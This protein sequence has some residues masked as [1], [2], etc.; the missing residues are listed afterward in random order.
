M[1]PS[2]HTAHGLIKA[3]TPKKQIKGEKMLHRINSDFK[4]R[5]FG[6]AVVF[7]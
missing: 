5:N 2:K 6:A 1:H 3:G 7:F 4:N